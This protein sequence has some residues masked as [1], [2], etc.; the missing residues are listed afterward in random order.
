[1]GQ[2]TCRGGFK[3]WWTVVTGVA[4]YLVLAWLIGPVSSGVFMTALCIHEAGHIWA[5]RRCGIGL[6]SLNFIP[7]VGAMARPASEFKSQDE[8][9]YIAIMGPAWGLGSALLAYLAYL[10]TGLP[11][12]ALVAKW[13]AIL[14]LFNLI[15]VSPLDGGRVI[16]SIVWSASERA[17]QILLVLGPVVLIGLTIYSRIWLLGLIAWFAYQEGK[18]VIHRHNFVAEARAIVNWLRK[19]YAGLIEDD[20]RDEESKAAFLKRFMLIVADG[21][22]YDFA[23]ETNGIADA[24][25]SK[26]PILQRPHRSVPE[27]CIFRHDLLFDLIVAAVRSEPVSVMGRRRQGA[28]TAA[29]LLLAG[30][31][32]A[33][34]YLGGVGSSGL[35]FNDLMGM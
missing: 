25:A 14:N 9:A 24:V 17:G 11:Q 15:P 32:A 2:Q 26:S 35:D 28:F 20:L 3:L 18:S 13:A 30:A 34:M 1:M 33:L 10:A 5:M 31:L 27:I 21:D 7:L 19:E 6:Q 12:L 4:F 29:Y 23:Y 16:K 22:F 8:E